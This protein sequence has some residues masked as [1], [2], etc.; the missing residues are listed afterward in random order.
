MPQSFTNIFSAIT[1]GVLL[2]ISVDAEKTIAYTV[3]DWFRAS[4]LAW[5][6]SLSFSMSILSI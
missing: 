5:Y 6:A 3:A 2:L 1:N 4:P